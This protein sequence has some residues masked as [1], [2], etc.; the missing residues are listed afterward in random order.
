MYPAIIRGRPYHC[1]FV[2]MSDASPPPAN[3]SPRYP[4]S[5]FY[6]RKQLVKGYPESPSFV[7]NSLRGNQC[8]LLL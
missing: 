2:L 7:N 3:N 1:V 4:P 6:S 5:A 8:P